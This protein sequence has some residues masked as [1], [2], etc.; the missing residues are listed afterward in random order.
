MRLHTAIILVGLIPSSAFASPHLHLEK[1]YQTAWCARN[2]GIMEVVLP[3]GSRVD[4]LTETHA[5]QV[6]KEMIK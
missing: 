2:I 6:K 4:C 5:V 3:G 1:E